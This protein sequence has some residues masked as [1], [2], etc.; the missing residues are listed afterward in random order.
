MAAE[1][2]EEANRALSKDDKMAAMAA[3]Q[4][5]KIGGVEGIL[6]RG[7]QVDYQDEDGYTLLMRA[8][9][10]GNLELV[11]LLLRK[12]ASVNLTSVMQVGLP[13][14]AAACLC[15]PCLPLPAAACLLAAD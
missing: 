4:A 7:L 6:D 11:T 13:L 15:V 14:L 1:A 2:A 9:E 8:A 3:A 10:S 12:G 5:G